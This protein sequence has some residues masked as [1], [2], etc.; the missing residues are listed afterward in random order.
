[1]VKTRETDGMA[2][3]PDR[4]AS[5][6]LAASHMSS[7]S[8]CEDSQSRWLMMIRVR[9][10]GMPSSLIEGELLLPSLAASHDEGFTVSWE[11]VV[12]SKE[13]EGFW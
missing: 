6:L 1:M 10:A 7:L 13:P 5:L 3:R 4:S 11:S 8:S 9:Y 2:V 12:R